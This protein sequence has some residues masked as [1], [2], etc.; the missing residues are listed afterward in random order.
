MKRIA[1]SALSVFGMLLLAQPATHAQVSFGPLDDYHAGQSSDPTFED[2][3]SQLPGP[4]EF[5]TAPE[6]RAFSPN[7]D[8]SG[9]IAPFY[10][11]PSHQYT[12]WFRPRAIGR[13]QGERCYGDTFRPRGY[14]H[15]FARPCNGQRMDYKPYALANWQTP[16][17]PA[18]YQL[19]EDPRCP[20]CDKQGCCLTNWLHGVS[21]GGCEQCE[22][23]CEQC[24]GGGCENCETCGGRGRVRPRLRRLSRRR[25]WAQLV[26]R[27]DAVDNGAFNNGCQCETCQANGANQGCASCQ[28]GNCTQQ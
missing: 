2:F 16:H 18:Y 10:A 17:G 25:N 3:G 4:E 14:G 12:G 28:S 11:L 19:A 26:T 27:G 6:Y 15:L 7:Q 24:E 23:G 8:G 22:G 13:T 20:Q 1:F 9:P 5:M 21:C